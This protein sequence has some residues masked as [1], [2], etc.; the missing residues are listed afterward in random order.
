MSTRPDTDVLVRFV[1][2]EARCLNDGRYADWLSLFARNGRYW[3]PLQGA[4]QDEHERHNALADEDRLLLGLRVDRLGHARAFSQQPRSRSQHVLQTP[5]VERVDQDPLQFTLYTPFIYVESRGHEQLMLA[6]HWLHR[7]VL[8]D[9]NLRIA[10]KRVNLLNADAQLPM[11][12][13]FP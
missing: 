13:L 12:Q 3:I 1:L 11:I 5:Q 2:D 4:R 7:L 9:G 10:L 8:E 6:G